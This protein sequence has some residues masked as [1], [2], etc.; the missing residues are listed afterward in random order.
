MNGNYEGFCIDLMDK[1]SEIMGFSYRFSLVEDGQFGGQNEDGSWN[2]MVGD[3]V[4][5]VSHTSNTYIYS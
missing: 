5:H 4:N 1:L 3:L 2:G